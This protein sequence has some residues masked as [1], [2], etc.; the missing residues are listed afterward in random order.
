MLG[1]AVKKTA[2]V[3]TFIVSAIFS[4]LA[5]EFQTTILAKGYYP[6]FY[7]GSSVEITFPE[8]GK[9][10]YSSTLT[11]RYDARFNN[12][13][14]KLVVYN[15]DGAGNVTIYDEYN[16]LGD[17]NGSVTL[18]GLSAGSHHIVLMSESGSSFSGWDVVYFNVAEPF[19]KTLVI[20]SASVLAVVGLS[21]FVYLKKRK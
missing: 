21:L 11:M 4:L 9:T 16:D 14:H 20:V 2:L 5:V 15:L 7:P 13:V 6:P 8:N 10:Y 3:V 12:V 17:I 19:P 18:S 1:I